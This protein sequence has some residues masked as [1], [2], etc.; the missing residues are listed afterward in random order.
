MLLFKF[1]IRDWNDGNRVN[2]NYSSNLKLAIEMTFNEL[3][4]V[5]IQIKNLWFEWT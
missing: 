2:S 5:M 4:S 1:K 3:I